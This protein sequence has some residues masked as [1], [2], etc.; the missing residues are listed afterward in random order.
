MNLVIKTVT[1]SKDHIAKGKCRDTQ[2]CAVALALSQLLPADASYR[3][4]VNGLAATYTRKGG[5]RV[6]IAL[7]KAVQ[8]FISR[9]DEKDEKRYVYSKT[10]GYDFRKRPTPRPI[11]FPMAVP[12]KG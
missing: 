4:S 10:G 3:V 2:K 7:P 8:S 11:S 9:F 12:V 5:S 1:V 6:R